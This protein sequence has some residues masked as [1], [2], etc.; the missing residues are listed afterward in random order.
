MTITLE[1]PDSQEKELR[2]IASQRGQEPEAFLLS[3]IDEAILF[4]GMEPIPNDDPEEYAASV[5]ALR[6]SIASIEAGRYR[7]AAQVFADMEQRHRIPS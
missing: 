5:A 1:L 4:E 7:P 6:R 2:G 3:L